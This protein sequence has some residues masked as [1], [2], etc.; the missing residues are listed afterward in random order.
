MFR[1]ERRSIRSLSSDDYRSC[2]RESI[3]RRIHSYFSRG[4]TSLTPTPAEDI[5]WRSEEK[6]IIF[7]RIDSALYKFRI[8]ASESAE[9][10]F[11]F[12]RAF[13]YWFPCCVGRLRRVA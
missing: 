4:G 9:P 11:H 8:L 12:R 7:V 1:P 13:V 6:R 2:Q 3:N 5:E 10:D